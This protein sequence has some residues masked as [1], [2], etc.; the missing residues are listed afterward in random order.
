MYWT[1]LSLFN[2]AESYLSFLLD[3][4]P[5]YAWFRLFICL[6]LVMPGQQGATHIYT[7]Y[8]HPWL[9]QHEREIEQFIAEAHDHARKAGM[10]YLKQALNWI[11]VNVLN[12]PPDPPTPPPSA[13][14]TY[15]QQLLSRF[16]MPASSAS[17]SPN[18]FYGMLSSALAGVSTAVGSGTASRAQAAHD[19]S[20]SGT[21]LPRELEGKGPD[22]KLRYLSS[23]R[24]SLRVLLQAFDKEAFS[25]ET[26]AQTGEVLP[27]SKSELDF[28]SVEK[29]ADVVSGGA[30]EGKAMPHVQR[31]S[32]GGAGWMP[33]NWA[34]KEGHEG[35]KKMQ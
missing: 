26:G 5:F 6:Y 10:G 33:W 31:R 23:T 24:E 18:D 14:Q 15:A 34:A 7:T 22:E 3:L 32:S 20:A 11:K 4:V 35:E 21:L 2:L 13:T 16:N 8:L 17:P 19:L 30:A 29:D 25:L 9:S 28:M 1:I 12:M 27:K